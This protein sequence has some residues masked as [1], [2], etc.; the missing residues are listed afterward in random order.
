MRLAVV[1]VRDLHGDSV[2]GEEQVRVVVVHGRRADHLARVV[3]ARRQ[4]RALPV[5]VVLLEVQ[6]REHE[7]VDE[8][9]LP[10]APRD[11]GRALHVHVA[12]ARLEG[13]GLPDELLLDVPREALAVQKV[14]PPRAVEETLLHALVGQLEHGHARL[15][16]PRAPALPR[17]VLLV[18]QRAPLAEVVPAVLVHVRALRGAEAVAVAQLVVVRVVIAVG[19]RARGGRRRGDGGEER[20]RDEQRRQPR[21]WPLLGRR[22]PAHQVR[23][24]LLGTSASP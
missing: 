12:E 3:V 17:E 19:G 22:A 24:V 16:R 9:P 15:A 4:Q 20:Q 23:A 14:V 6:A 2:R 5:V 7:G 21:H 10:G 11:Q 13:A 1:E 18:V 8:T